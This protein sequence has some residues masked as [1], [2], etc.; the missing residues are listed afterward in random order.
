MQSALP[1][2][3]RCPR[4]GRRVRGFTLIELLVVV[5]IIALL[6]AILLPSLKSAREQ[7]KAAV[8]TANLKGLA[9]ASAIY[10]MDDDKE[11]AV[12]VHELSL[13]MTIKHDLL[14]AQF[15]YG[16]KSGRGR[17]MGNPGYWGTGL[18]KGPATRPLNNFIYKEG[19]RNYHRYNGPDLQDK[20]K[21][22]Q[23]LPLDMFRCPSDRGHTGDRTRFWRDSQLS[24]YDFFG[25]SYYANVLWVG[26]SGNG[27]RMWSNSPFLRPLSRVPTPANTLYFS[28]A[29]GRRAF[30]VTEGQPPDRPCDYGDDSIKRV[31]GWHKKPWTFQAAFVDTHAGTIVVR[32]Y[33]SPPLGAY[34]GY[35]FDEWQCV[36]FRGDNWQLDTLPSPPMMTRTRCIVKPNSGGDRTRLMLSN[37]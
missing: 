29:C 24:A 25:N 10:A 6:I 31:V 28:E 5:S 32:G 19:F 22:D 18:A 14:I 17:Y 36:T 33:N 11:Q 4:F 1:I 13:E 9:T 12:P 20:W 7:A 34:P 23:N 26:I 21:G 27:C 2:Y 30:W 35:G 37:L 8:C 16:G 15:C 3:P